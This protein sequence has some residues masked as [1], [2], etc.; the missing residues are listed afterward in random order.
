MWL[1]N[2]KAMLANCKGDIFPPGVAHNWWITASSPFATMLAILFAPT[3]RAEQNTALFVTL[4]R[5]NRMLKSGHGLTHRHKHI[6]YNN[7]K[8]LLQKGWPFLP[9]SKTQAFTFAYWVGLEFLCPL[10][11]PLGQVVALPERP[12]SEQDTSS[13]DCPVFLFSWASPRQKSQ[14]GDGAARSFSSLPGIGSNI[15]NIH[16]TTQLR[17]HCSQHNQWYH[18]QYN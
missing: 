13:S 18:Q 7:S 9:T 5:C 15:C 2:M 17:W 8:Y 11:H 14:Y 10:P 4:L 6:S 3:P 16:H 12:Q 1:T